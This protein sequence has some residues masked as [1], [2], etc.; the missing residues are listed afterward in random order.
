MDA[1]AEKKNRHQKE[2]NGFPMFFAFTND[3]FNAGMK[4]LGL[5]QED[6]DKIYKLGNTGGY[7]RRD[8]AENLHGMFERHRSEMQAAIE[9]DK[10]GNGFIFQMFHYELANHE[11]VVTGDLT[12]TLNAL[13]LTM[14]DVQNSKPLSNGLNK[15]ITKVEKEYMN[16]KTKRR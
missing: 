11:Y 6:T 12:D 15:A 2:V 10:K 14:E 7:Y 16:A 1:Y 3:Q 4:K 13:G 5:N 8:D 9:A